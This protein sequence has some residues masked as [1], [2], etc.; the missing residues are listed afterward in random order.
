MHFLTKLR[1]SRDAELL[2]ICLL[3]AVG[4]FGGFLFELLAPFPIPHIQ[5]GGPLFDRHPSF[6]ASFIRTLL[7]SLRLPVGHAFADKF[8]QI[9]AGDI[10]MRR[11]LRCT[12]GCLACAMRACSWMPA[13]A[14]LCNDGIARNQKQSKGYCK[15]RQ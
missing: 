5:D 13:S 10:F 3:V 7:S 11:L 4:P 1:R 6:Y 15:S 12:P 14:D 2:L 8:G 9:P